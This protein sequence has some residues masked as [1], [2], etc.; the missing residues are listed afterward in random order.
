MLRY[1]NLSTVLALGGVS[2]WIDG[3]AV[4][5]LTSCKRFQ[6]LLYHQEIEPTVLMLRKTLAGTY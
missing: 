5:S 4:A 6:V 1:L 3:V 2:E